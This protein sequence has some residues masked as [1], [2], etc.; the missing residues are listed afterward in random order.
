MPDL[1][2]ATT[3][4]M[5]LLKILNSLDIKITIV[6]T[7]PHYP[8]G[9]IPSKYKP[10]WKWIEQF[11]KVKV[12]RMRMLPIAHK[13][14]A[15]RMINH[16]FFILMTIFALPS[17]RNIDLIWVT[18]PNF[19]G[20]LAGILY[21]FLKRVPLIINIDDFWPDVVQ[22]LGYVNSKFLLKLAHKFNIFA[23]KYCNSITPISSMIKKKLV[24]QYSVPSHKVHVIEVGADYSLLKRK[25]SHIENFDRNK[26]RDH[27]LQFTAIYSG[28]LG[29]AYDFEMLLKA[30]TELEEELKEFRMVIHG[31][32]AFQPFIQSSIANLQLRKTILLTDHLSFDDYMSFLASASVFLLPMKKGIFSETAIPA[33]IFTYLMYDKPIISTKGGAV[34]VILNKSN[35]GL[36]I[37]HDHNELVQKLRLLMEDEEMYA[38]YCGNGSKYVREHLDLIV[39]KKKVIDLLNSVFPENCLLFE[40]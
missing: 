4:L 18:S 6:T 7:V 19:F 13:T 37:S 5:N 11:E 26:N 30:A 39:L 8:T 38:Q 17:V 1:G 22:E 28:I 31:K 12:V 36:A 9:E 34:E 20:N 32:G 14:S 10:N 3:R 2:G 33:K 27:D 16:F 23:F 15:N 29:P 40:K 25:I 24:E 35:A 21:K